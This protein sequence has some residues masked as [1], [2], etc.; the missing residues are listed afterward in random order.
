MLTFDSSEGVMYSSNFVI[1]RGRRKVVRYLPNVDRT[2]CI[3]K[4]VHVVLAFLQN[5]ARIVLISD[6]YTDDEQWD[7][8]VSY[9]CFISALSL[10]I[11]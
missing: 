6:S 7:G 1:A 11:V 5:V 3:V 9:V 2:F 10:M 8:Y 4:R